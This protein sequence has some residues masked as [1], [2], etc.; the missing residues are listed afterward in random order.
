[1]FKNWKKIFVF[2]LV[3]MIITTFPALGQTLSDNSDAEYIKF[4]KQYA[5]DKTIK[6]KRTGKLLSELL[7]QSGSTGVICGSE[8]TMC[9]ENEKCWKCVTQ[10]TITRGGM[11]AGT[12]TSID[13][14]GYCV[15][16][17]KDKEYVK[18][19]FCRTNLRT[20][21]ISLV[22]APE[23]FKKKTTVSA[24]GIVQVSLEKM[25]FVDKDN[26]KYVL[27]YDD[28]NPTLKYADKDTT[29]EG[30]EVLPIKLH[31][32]SGCFFCPLARVIYDTANEVT[33]LSISSFAGAFQNLMI[34]AFAIWLAFSSLNIV[35]TLTKQDASKYITGM[36]KQG[37]KFLFAYFLLSNPEDLF[38]FF[39]EPVL[40][41]GMNMGT[42]I[43][44][45][46][47]AASLNEP[48]EGITCDGGNFFSNELYCKIH[49][50]LEDV[51][52]QLA[53]LQAI[54][55]TLFCIGGNEI[56]VNGL[57][58]IK[59]NVR[60]IMSDFLLGAI[61]FIFGILLTISFAFYFLDSMLQLCVLGAMLPMMIA[62]WPF[63]VTA[64]YATE[65][66]KML[67]NTTFTMFFTGFVVSVELKLISESLNFAKE[68]SDA[69]KG[70]EKGLDDIHDSVSGLAGIFDEINEQD[71]K[72]IRDYTNI[73]AK[74]FLL[75]GFAAIFGFKFVSQ[76][77]KMSNKLAGGLN[78]GISSRVGTMMASSAKGM[79][80]KASKPMRDSMSE[81][82]HAGGGL[83]GRVAKVGKAPGALINKLGAKNKFI[84]KFQTNMQERAE[85]LRKRA[86]EAK[87]KGGFINRIKSKFLSG[88]AN[89]AEATG[90][91]G[92]V[93][94]LASRIEDKA[95][96]VH[97]AYMASEKYN[98]H[99]QKQEEKLRRRRGESDE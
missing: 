28:G 82:W 2:Q 51:Q 98:E 52:H 29:V 92:F 22:E 85:N 57:F 26:H 9:K 13:E 43:L 5:D 54:G 61:L 63:K 60:N 50:F 8:Q 84:N 56:S 99:R 65:G 88:A 78:L 95:K 86:E 12:N 72:G 90:K 23:G 62:G 27:A 49:K 19:N 77:T 70:M 53:V 64:K 97:N 33:D 36:L 46:A 67:L 6:S 69:A 91:Y 96:K 39:I 66:L 16:S 11:N 47:N 15:D 35:F 44:S 32:M 80:L 79:A 75:I 93:G 31:K 74:G 55:T 7:D 42:A 34:V 41:T 21:L 4:L 83:I 40:E 81:K 58:K 38:R 45:E 3:V 18:K 89:R 73:G 68:S 24:G 17:S 14:N 48:P 37:G 20:S 94:G 1:M 10:T 71:T 76:I 87:L 59:E 25:T 30:C